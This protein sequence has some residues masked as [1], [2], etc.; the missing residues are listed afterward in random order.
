MNAKQK[1]RLDQFH[2]EM[3]RAEQRM[4][5][6]IQTIQGAQNDLQTKRARFESAVE[7]IGGTGATWTHNPEDGV[8]ILEAAEKPP[9]PEPVAKNGAGTP[10]SHHNHETRRAAKKALGK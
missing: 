6:A 4:Q 1:K 8:V 10:V 5:M 9:T 7:F 2:D 3:Q